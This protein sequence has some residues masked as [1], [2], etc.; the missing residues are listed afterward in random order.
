MVG[1]G[2]VIVFELLVV[3]DLVVGWLFVL[4]GFVVI[5]G[6]WVLVMLEGI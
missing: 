2:V 6:F 4:W 1:L 3:D 5:G